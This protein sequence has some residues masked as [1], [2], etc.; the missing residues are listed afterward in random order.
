[1]SLCCHPCPAAAIMAQVMGPE[2]QASYKVRVF[3]SDLAHWESWKAEMQQ[4]LEYGK[5]CTDV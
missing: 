2:G 1:M 4:N 5:H 3:E